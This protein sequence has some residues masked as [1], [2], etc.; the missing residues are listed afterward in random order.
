[1][2]STYVSGFHAAALRRA[3]GYAY[4]MFFETCESNVFPRTPRWRPQYVG[5]LPEVLSQIVEYVDCCDG[6]MTKGARGRPISSNTF[7]RRCEQALSVANLVT[8]QR[9]TLEFGR[10]FGA[11]AP[12]RLAA[13]DAAAQAAGIVIHFAR[14]DDP[15]GVTPA[16]RTVDLGDPATVEV[17]LAFQREHQVPLWQIFEMGRSA[18]LP[19]HGDWTPPAATPSELDRVSEA[20]RQ[21]LGTHRVVKLRC[22]WPERTYVQEEYLVL[23]ARHQILSADPLR[24]FCQGFLGDGRCKKLAE[25]SAA[26]KAFRAW[27]AAAT[28]VMDAATCEVVA[29]ATGA[30]DEAAADLAEKLT[31]GRSHSLPARGPAAAVVRELRYCEAARFNVVAPAPG[32]HATQSLF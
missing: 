22:P 29:T 26:L 4:V 10:A 18:R 15:Q 25:S 17:V 8:D 31:D 16:I 9:V 2:S 27:M 7:V 23:D 11:I 19:G 12:D 21:H 24:W 5:S 13:F 28:V 32:G 14:E 6:G 1:M 20:A 3:S 30:S